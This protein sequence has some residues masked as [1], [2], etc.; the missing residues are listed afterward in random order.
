LGSTLF[1]RATYKTHRFERH[2]HEEFAIGIIESG[3]QAFTFDRAQRMD[4]PEGVVSLISPGI[5]HEGWPGGEEGWA[6]RMLYPSF[7][8][9]ATASMDIF[10]KVPTGFRSPV[11]HDPSLYGKICNLHVACEEHPHDGLMIESLYLDV[12]NFALVSHASFAPPPKGTVHAEA[13]RTLREYLE[14]NYQE[15]P[16][17]DE[18]RGIADMSKFHLLRQFKSVFGL[19]PHAYLRQIRIHRARSLILTGMSLVDVAATVGFA[20]QAHMTRAF[21][22]SYGF[23]PGALLNTR[24]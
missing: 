20:D 6:Y 23:T 2:Y 4:M 21:R 12:V 22:R 7:D 18:L 24:D 5:V 16:T 15:A 1:L 17:L 10:G 19:P 3:V 9:L 11:V 13:M 8:D 14:A